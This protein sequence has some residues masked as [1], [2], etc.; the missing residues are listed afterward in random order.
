MT[1]SHITFKMTCLAK[2]HYT[3][4]EFMIYLK[5]ISCIINYEMLC[6]ALAL[7]RLLQPCFVI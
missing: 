4:G 7:K 5:L 6:W 1:L 2:H 3:F